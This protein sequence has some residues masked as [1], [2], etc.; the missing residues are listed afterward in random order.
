MDETVSN[1]PV[2]GN[3]AQMNAVDDSQPK[4]KR[5][6]YGETASNENHVLRYIPAEKVETMK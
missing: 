5:P 6:Q 3:V 2:F 1:R 4:T